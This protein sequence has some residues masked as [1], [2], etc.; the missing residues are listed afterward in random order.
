M[1]GFHTLYKGTEKNTLSFVG[2]NC[3]CP[4]L[5][6]E[7]TKLRQYKH[8]SVQSMPLLGPASQSSNALHR[9]DSLHIICTKLA[10]PGHTESS[11]QP[12]CWQ[13]SAD[14]LRCRRYIGSLHPF[15]LDKAHSGKRL[16][17]SKWSFSNVNTCT[18]SNKVKTY[19]SLRVTSRAREEAHACPLQSLA[20]SNTS[21]LPFLVCFPRTPWRLP[22][23]P[24]PR[25]ATAM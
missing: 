14:S 7:G 18:D 25:T 20:F 13:L 23:H 12:C 8:T 17:T 5:W 2:D 6:H 10:V 24:H 15:R 9:H 4:S 11:A 19:M 3:I 21:F 22:Q 16:F 1:Q